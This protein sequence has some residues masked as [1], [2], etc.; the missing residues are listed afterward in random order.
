MPFTILYYLVVA[1]VM[2]LLIINIVYPL[3]VPRHKLFFMFRRDEIKC[4]EEELEETIR[5]TELCK[6]RKKTKEIKKGGEE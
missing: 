1:L 3:F 5:E 4:A 6:L 2:A